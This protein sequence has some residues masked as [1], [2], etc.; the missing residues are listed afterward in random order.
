MYFLPVV[1]M[2]GRVS[3]TTYEPYNSRLMYH[4]LGSRADAAAG[5]LASHLP[6]THAGVQW[7][8]LRPL[9]W[10]SK[11]SG[12]VP[13]MF[14]YPPPKPVS[15]GSLIS[16]RCEFLD[17]VML[18][19]G[20]ACRQIV[21]LGAGWD[22]RSY[23]LL[24]QYDGHVFEVDQEGTQ[25]VKQHAVN[26]SGMG[27]AMVTYVSCDFNDQK[28]LDALVD[29]G[30]NPNLPTYIHWEGVMMYLQPDAVQQ[31][32]ETLAGL[33]KGSMIGCDFFTSG[34]LNGTWSGRLSA[35]AVGWFYGEPFTYGLPAG[36][37]FTEDL[38]KY[39]DRFGLELVEDEAMGSVGGDLFG[40]LVVVR[41]SV[42]TLSGP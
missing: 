13:V 34:W 2:R 42:G 36:D 1:A 4:L 11:L 14:R 28:W 40:G 15:M 26:V 22:T 6:A 19:H 24:D 33:G 29:A 7:T 25:K 18:Q 5:T 38:R 23:G 10:I 9:A 16:V 3:G 8:L 30:F 41:N 17:R 35:R 32:W 12:Y 39:F 31:T 20:M 37:C 27:S 21:I